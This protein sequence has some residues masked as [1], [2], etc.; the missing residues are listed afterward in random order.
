MQKDKK[1]LNDGGILRSF[2]FYTVDEV[3]KR[4]KSSVLKRCLYVV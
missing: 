3:L 2:S 4:G 1:Y